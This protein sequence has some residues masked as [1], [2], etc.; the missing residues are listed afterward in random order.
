MNIENNKVVFLH[1]PKTGGGAM[2]YLFYNETKNIRRSYMFN[3]NGY[4]DSQFYKDGKSF[5]HRSGSNSELIHQNPKK[6]EE[7]KNH[8]H[9]KECKL[10]FGHIS[11]SFGE[12]FPEYNFEY[13][14]VVREPVIRALSNIMQFTPSNGDMVSI[15]SNHEKCEVGS[16][17][18]WDFLYEVM[19][20]YPVKGIM[21]HNN[22]GLSNCQTRVFQGAKYDSMDEKVDLD[23]A[24]ENSKH[25]HYSFFN[26]FNNGL[27]RSFDLTN[28]PINMSNNKIG[29]KGL[30]TSQKDKQNT[31][32]EFY[33]ADKKMIDLVKELNDKDIKLYEYLTNNPKV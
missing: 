17:K 18:Y 19:S 10:I 26:D 27:Q 29:S 8:Q 14:T 24:I 15:G 30:P 25:I 28:I 21:T 20:N 11:Y 13:I 2:R 31:L 7:Y 16:K 23:K 4:D 5:N 22:H 32:G 33:G 3:L 9:F 1:M 12:L 6:V